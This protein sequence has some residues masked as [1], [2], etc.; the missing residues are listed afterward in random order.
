MDSFRQFTEKYPLQSYKKGETIL[1]KG[2][3]P[4]GVLIVESGLIKMYSI[5]GTGYERL[6]AIDRRGEDFPIGF[7]FG[8]IDKS[9]FFYNA[10]TR[11][12]V[13]IIPQDKFLTHLHSNVESMYRH[14]IRMTNLLLSTLSRVHALEQS[15]AADKIAHTLFYMASQVGVILRPYKAKLE[16]SVT[17]QEIAN[18][19]GLSRETTSIELKKLEALHLVSHTRKRYT[20]YQ[21]QL[22]KY[23]DRK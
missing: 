1:L 22:Q 8:L 13:R 6:V 20:L 3:K 10:Y 17:Q 5:T 18:S 2:E 9:Q 7:A 23:I 4:K 19:L 16:I 11:C 12:S 14:H 21:E 15:T